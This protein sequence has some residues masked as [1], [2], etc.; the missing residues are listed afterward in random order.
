MKPW[1]LNGQPG[2]GSNFG[3]ANHFQGAL[4]GRPPLNNSTGLKRQEAI[5][6]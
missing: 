4:G 6:A 1:E 3:P 2:I 5:N